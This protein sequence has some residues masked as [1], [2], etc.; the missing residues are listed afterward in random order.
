VITRED[1]FMGRDI[2]HPLDLTPEIEANAYR[3]VTI[4]NALLALFGQTRKVN[5]GWRPACGRAF[6]LCAQLL[7]TPS[8]TRAVAPGVG[9]GAKSHRSKSPENA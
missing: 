6:G 8:A 2:S 3:T 5:S 4:V 9:S 1:Y 7:G